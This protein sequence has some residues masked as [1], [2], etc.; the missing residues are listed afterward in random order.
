MT[1]PLAAL[2]VPSGPA[3]SDPATRKTLWRQVLRAVGLVVL[4]TVLAL[5]GSLFLDENGDTRNGVPEI[6]P[7]PFIGGGG[8]IILIG[9]AGLIGSARIRW[10]LRRPW[11]RV[12]STYA[13]IE[14]KAGPNGQP[15]LVLRA[16]TSQWTLTLAAVVWRW[17]RFA[18]SDELLFAGVRSGVVATLDRRAL[19]LAGRSPYTAYL[20]WRSRRKR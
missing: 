13:N 5:L 15:V 7:F 8:F 2:G 1:D 9:L 16:G 6:V 12:E 4:G 3:W 11:I 14:T 18:E 10:R 19:A 20:L 17:K